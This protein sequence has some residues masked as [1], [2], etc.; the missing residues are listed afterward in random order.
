MACD[1]VFAVIASLPSRKELVVNSPR[2]VAVKECVKEVVAACAKEQNRLRF[3]RFSVDLVSLLGSALERSGPATLSQR[4]ESLWVNFC[5][6]RAKRLPT[7]WKTFL[8]EICCDSAAKEPLFMELVNESLLENL[9]K[10]M[11]AVPQCLPTCTMN[12]SKDEENII[13]YAC[14]Y[15]GMKLYNRFVKQPGEKAAA[16]VE[17]IDHMR[18]EGPTSSLQ[19]YTREWVEKVN[20]GGLFD[21]SDEAYNLFIAIE[22]A[23][24]YRLTSHLKSSVSLEPADAKQGKD[25]IIDHV[26]SDCD[27]QFHW[28]L[29][30]VDIPDDKDGFELLRNIIELWLTIRG[31]SISKAWMEEYKCIAKTSTK[32]K[33]SLRKDLRK[34]K[35]LEPQTD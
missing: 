26:L 23:M 14:G 32:G 21:V 16:F 24:L 31:F 25:A 6:L 30:S 8:T 3:D 2:T 18:A 7:L 10:E 28:S 1:E 5:K 13:R 35:E 4:R 15:V 22:V 33:K 34:R 11:Y 9:T 19:E 17:C 27:V 29:L 20:R 12:L